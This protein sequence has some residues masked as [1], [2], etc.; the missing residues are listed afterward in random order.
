MLCLR[1][2]I[3]PF[4]NGVVVI[5]HWRIHNYIRKD[6][7]SE[8][9]YKEQ[10]A[11]LEFDENNAYRMKTT[12]SVLP[13][14]DPSTARQ[15][16][17]DAGK[18]RLGQD[19]IGKDRLGQ[20]R[21]EESAELQAAPALSIILNDG[22]EYDF[23]QEYVDQMQKLYPAVDVMAEMLKMKA[24]C[25]NNPKRRKTRRGI[26]SFVGNWLSKEQDKGGIY[27]ESARQG[28]KKQNTTFMD[29]YER[30]QAEKNDGEGL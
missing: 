28:G 15:R 23:S 10:K 12:S 3:I 2:F 21:I 24:W 16:D 25:I 13:V 6:T 27:K 14:N 29:I 26:T 17:V 4:D 11:M 5:K 30:R 18:D 8:T 9:P 22:T 1:K 20:D 19:R 7:Y